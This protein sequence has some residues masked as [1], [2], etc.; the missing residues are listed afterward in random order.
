MVATYNGW[1]DTPEEEREAL[2]LWEMAE[3]TPGM[4]S[5]KSRASGIVRVDGIETSERR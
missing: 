2:D 5:R 1:E 4:F 3:Q